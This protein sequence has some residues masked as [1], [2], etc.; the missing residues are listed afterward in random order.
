MS[1]HV[2]ADAGVSFWPQIIPK[3]FSSIPIFTQSITAFNCQSSPRR[4]TQ[5]SVKPDAQTQIR[6]RDQ[7]FG[8]GLL[9]AK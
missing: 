5:G 9:R 4:G 1:V 6:L 3:T 8:F 7:A 2:T